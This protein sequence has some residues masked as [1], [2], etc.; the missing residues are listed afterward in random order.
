[1]V[2]SNSRRVVRTTPPFDGRRPNDLSHPRAWICCGPDTRRR[3]SADRGI[4]APCPT[5]C[6]GYIAARK[7]PMTHACATTHGI[8]PL[9]WEGSVNTGIAAA[10]PDT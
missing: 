3:S 5:R 4:R 10:L 8:K 1:M 2:R 7:P 6:V 9:T